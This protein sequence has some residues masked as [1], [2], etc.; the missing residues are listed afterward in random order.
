MR[1]FLSAVAAVGFLGGEDALRAGLFISQLT[2]HDCNTEFAQ[3]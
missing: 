1:V 2:L 3:S